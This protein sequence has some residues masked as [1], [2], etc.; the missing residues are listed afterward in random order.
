MSSSPVP[1]LATPFHQ[2]VPFSEE[3]GYISFISVFDVPTPYST[4]VFHFLSFLLIT[5]VLTFVVVAWKSSAFE[6]V[7]DVNQANV[8]VPSAS[9]ATRSIATEEINNL[10]LDV[11]FIE[12]FL[13]NKIIFCP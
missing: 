12:K 10:F 2:L 9:I 4:C 5:S 1:S 3:A 8:A 6:V 11:V 13:L 7:F